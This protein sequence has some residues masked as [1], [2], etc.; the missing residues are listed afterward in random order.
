M[1]SIFIAIT[2]SVSKYKHFWIMT[3]SQ[4]YYFDQQYL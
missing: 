4:K 2:L 1:I 3:K